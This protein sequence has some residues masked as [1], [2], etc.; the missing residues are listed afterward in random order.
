M[1]GRTRRRF[2]DKRRTTLYTTTTRA[3][4]HV[5]TIDTETGDGRTDTIDGH[6]HFIEGLEVKAVHGH[7]H[8]LTTTRGLR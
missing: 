4:R 2:V 5:A 3:H 6:F 7:D 8:E 1:Q